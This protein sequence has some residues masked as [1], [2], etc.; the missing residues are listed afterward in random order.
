[1]RR[2]RRTFWDEKPE[3]LDKK[4]QRRVQ[5]HRTK[6]YCCIPNNPKSIKKKQANVILPNLQRKITN[7]F[8][9]SKIN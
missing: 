9:L 8:D 4:K 3:Q 2:L 6:S 5:T 1:M 7:Y